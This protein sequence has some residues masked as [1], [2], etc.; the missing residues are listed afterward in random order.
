VASFAL[1]LDTTAPT[2][3]W[4]AVG[5]ATAG[6]L[7][8]LAYSADEPI[9]GAELILAD[10]RVFALTVA[11]GE[12]RVML[13]A[14]TPQGTASVRVRDDVGNE[15]T[16]PALVAL[17][18]A[19]VVPPPAPTPVPRTGGPP[20]RA[21]RQRSRVIRHTSRV[22]ARSACAVRARARHRT[23]VVAVAR[24]AAD[25][26]VQCLTRIT[27]TTTSRLQSVLSPGRRH[28]LIGAGVELA[29]RRRD[30]PDQELLLLL[31]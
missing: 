23:T 29:V 10:G 19:I 24:T 18:G 6:E 31:L 13:P 27:P 20:R 4:G 9:A 30:G 15:R 5:G 28:A 22:V 1:V 8:R 25:C 11:A 17:Q 21:A 7:L 3:S 16:Y 14:D 12:L 2:V 26:S